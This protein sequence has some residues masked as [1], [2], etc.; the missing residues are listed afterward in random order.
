MVRRA[1]EV[2]VLRSVMSAEGTAAPEGSRTVPSIPARN[3]PNVMLESRKKRIEM[4]MHSSFECAGECAGAFPSL[5]R[6]ID[7]I[8]KIGKSE[9]N[10]SSPEQ[11]PEGV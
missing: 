1:A 10:Q 6:I 7:R 5:T 9:E 11:A 8:G 4:R 2:P 3:W